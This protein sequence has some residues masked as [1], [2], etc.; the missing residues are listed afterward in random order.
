M[1][2]PARRLHAI[3]VASV[4]LLLAAPSPSSARQS[5]PR[6]DTSR[7]LRIEYADGNV[8]T[9]PLHRTGGMWTPTFPTIAGAQTARAGV[10][11]T[12]LDVKHVMDGTDVV[13]TVSLFYGGPG[14]NGVEVANVRV[15]PSEPVKIDQLRA[16]GVEP[17]V[18]SLVPIAAAPAYAPDVASVSGQLGVR[19]EAVGPN[20]SA[21]RVTVT[22]RSSLPLMWL[23][24][25]AFRGGTGAAIS[26][27]PRGKRNAPLVMP[28][29]DYTFE[30]TTSTGGLAAADASETWQPLDRIEVTSLMWQDGLVE[31]D[32]Q[33][34]REQRGVDALRVTQ[35]KAFLAVLRDAYSQP[36]A[37]IRERVAKG[38]T[39]DLE[40]RR[41]RDAV[42][43]DLD[44]LMR[45]RRS[46]DGQNLA[47]WL[48]A[49]IA[50]YEQWLA[51]IPRAN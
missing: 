35:I 49:T 22:N 33:S 30:I 21:Y 48:T 6:T 26:G 11:L 4:A 37:A 51:R 5:P 27:R 15:T 23:Q 29:A 9:G 38:M 40:T 47:T 34:A 17:I 16:Y 28:N 8:S 41:G 43:A 13:V 10:P 12:T 2:V 44:E 45:T 19:A 3:R 31:G 14:R 24:F 25:K 32:P 39:S 46:R 36:L 18:L 50:E 20:V 42:L 1:R 7:G